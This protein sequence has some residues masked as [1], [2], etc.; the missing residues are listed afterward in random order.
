[1][2]RNDV[3]KI[4]EAA[5]ETFP[6]ICAMLKYDEVVFAGVVSAMIE[7]YAKYHEID[8]IELLIRIAELYKEQ[9]DEQKQ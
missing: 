1:M 5:N 6:A 9:E 3:E 7:M 8:K 2:K 4:L